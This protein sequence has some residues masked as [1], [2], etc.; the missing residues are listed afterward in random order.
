MGVQGGLFP[1][2]REMGGQDC[3]RR[4][5]CPAVDAVRGRTGDKQG[6]TGAGA[7]GETSTGESAGLSRHPAGDTEVLG[8]VGGKLIFLPHF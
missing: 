4:K 1:E 6:D 2:Q 7:E 3:R 5:C 8:S